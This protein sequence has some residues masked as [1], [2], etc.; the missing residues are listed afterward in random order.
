MKRTY[1]LD[2]KAHPKGVKFNLT[3]VAEDARRWE[4]REDAVKV[5]DKYF[6]LDYKGARIGGRDARIEKSADGRYVVG[7]DVPT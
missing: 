2:Y 5:V 4:S 7:F 3:S 6:P 1:I